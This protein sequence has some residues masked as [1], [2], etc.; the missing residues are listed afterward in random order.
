MCAGWLVNLAQSWAQLG[1]LLA[2]LCD[3]HAAAT[4]SQQK[5][6]GR[7]R[8]DIVAQML[9][10]ECRCCTCSGAWSGSLCRRC[11]AEV[12]HFR[13]DI[14]V[15]TGVP[16]C[17]LS[18]PYQGC[19]IIHIPIPCLLRVSLLHTAT[20]CMNT[21]TLL[22]L[23]LL[24]VFAVQGIGGIKW[25]GRKVVTTVEPC[26]DYYLAEAYHQQYLEK[27]GRFGSPQSAAKGC[28]DPI[29]CYG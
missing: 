1:K 25:L 21:A 22:L 11:T 2:S 6:Q 23:L 14:I 12:P 16:A 24:I 26:G 7:A 8:L 15:S 28:N 4:L 27:G 5:L 19:L 17:R 13:H 20:Y 29:R 9:H 18:G 3:T 10:K